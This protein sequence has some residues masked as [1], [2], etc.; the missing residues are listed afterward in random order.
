MAL[1][2]HTFRIFISS[3]FNDLKAERNALQAYVFPRLREL[4]A[5]H[6]RRL[7]VIDLRWGVSDEASLDQQAMDICLAEVTRCQKTTPRP[8]FV[9][10]LGDRY[11]WCPPPA[12]IPSKKYA[13]ILSVIDNKEDETLLKEWYYLDENAV[14]PQWLLKPR[15]RDSVFAEHDFW[16]PVEQKLQMIIA[17]AISRLGINPIEALPYLSSATEQEISAGALQVKDADEH[18]LCFFRSISGLPHDFQV[19]DFRKLLSQSFSREFENKPLQTRI[20]QL[21]ET[22]LTN[23]NYSTAFEISRLV[24]N[25]L[26]KIPNHTFEEDALKLVYQTLLD[27]CAADF[28]NI[29]EE[30]WTLDTKAVKQQELLKERLKKRLPNNI[31]EYHAKWIE[32]SLTTDHID[33]LCQDVYQSLSTLIMDEVAH[34]HTIVQEE[35]KK[36]LL[37]LDPLLDEEGLAHQQFAEEKIEFFIGRTQVLQNIAAYLKDNSKKL[38]GIVGAGGTG[39]TAVMAKAVQESLHSP[40]EK[41]I[42]YR[43]IGATARSSDIHSLLGS[44]CSEISRRYSQVESSTPEDIRELITE[45]GKRLQ[46][47]NS[48]KPL[49][50]FL[51]SLD[52]LSD[53]HD[54]RSLKWLPLELP[55][56]V[57]LVLSTREEETFIHLQEKKCQFENLSGLSPEE[58]RVLLT[59]WLQNIERTLQIPQISEVIDKFTQTQGNPLYLKL[60]FEEA[61]LWNSDL[62]K[63]IENLEPGINGIIEKNMLDRLSKEDNH[64]EILVSHALGYLAASRFGLSEDEIMDLLSR[65]SQVYLWFFLNSHHIPPDLLQCA[66]D[67]LRGEKPRPVD[68]DL[69]NQEERAAANWLGEMRNP[70][71]KVMDFLNEVLPKKDGP[72]LPIVLWSRLSFDLAPYLTERIVDGSTLMTFYH[73]ELGDV[74]KQVF[75]SHEYGKYFHSHLADYFHVK[76]DPNDDG[77]WDGGDKHALSELPFHLTKAGRM[78]DVISL[79]TD[80]NFLEHKANEVNIIDQTNDQGETTKFYLGVLQLQEDI[81]RVLNNSTEDT[82]DESGLTPLIVTAVQEKGRLHL[83]CPQCNRDSTIDLSELG[84]IITCPQLDCNRKLKLNAFFTV[85]E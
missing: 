73:S 71:E 61:K 78:E 69:I 18:V 24:K 32:N 9:I 15:L 74:A 5:E 36:I 64:G 8:N 53:S 1:A 55:E 52:Q 72:R 47:A 66:A 16:Q 44:I 39:K 48:E 22:I 62:S 42:V 77:C 10:L 28:R 70:P 50:L 41:A 12:H 20:T 83:H 26:E 33:Q 7:Q 17:S 76:G 30:D 19:E 56:Y 2:Q 21:V 34:P 79:L 84:Q 51:D 82:G 85:L 45:F 81:D 25:E 37:P 13:Q 3:T 65:D 35:K 75:C 80:F 11:G 6:D 4:A 58:G 40:Q 23:E 60:A 27:H 57:H 54:A 59:Q 31:Y 14:E 43:F 67:H 46:L 29:N 49:Y 38:F 68:V 63:P